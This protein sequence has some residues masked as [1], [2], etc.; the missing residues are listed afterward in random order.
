MIGVCP[1]VGVLNIHILHAGAVL[2]EDKY[3]SYYFAV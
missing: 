1:Q 3:V 2:M